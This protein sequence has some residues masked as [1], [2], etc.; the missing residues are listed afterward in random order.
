MYVTTNSRVSGSSWIDS[1]NFF[2]GMCVW[3][4]KWMMSVLKNNSLG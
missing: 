2:D 1:F 3:K 4:L